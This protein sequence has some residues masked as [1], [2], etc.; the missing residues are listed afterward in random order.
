MTAQIGDKFKIKNENYTFV[1]MSEPIGFHPS[2]YG[3]RPSHT[4]TACWRGFWCEYQI[5]EKGIF[6]KELYVNSFDGNY[7][8]IDG[9]G[10]ATEKDGSPAM[11]MSH[12]VY[13]GLNIPVPFSGKILVGDKFLPGFYIHMGHQMPWAYEILKELVFEDGK[14][15]ETNDLSAVAATLRERV[16]KGDFIEEDESLHYWWLE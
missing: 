1:A 5:S 12:H 8:L 10:I 4:C 2:R 16:Q 9:V 14:L 13:K 15:L 6:V 3:I 7:P 11:Y